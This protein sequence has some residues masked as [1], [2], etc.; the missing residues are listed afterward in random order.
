VGSLLRQ[1]RRRRPEKRMRLTIC[2]DDGEN[3]T[4][5]AIA[6]EVECN[7]PRRRAVRLGSCT[8]MWGFASHVVQSSKSRGVPKRFQS[9]F[10]VQGTHAAKKIPASKGGHAS[11]AQTCS[12]PARGKNGESPHIDKS[13]RRGDE[14]RHFKRRHGARQ[15]PG[16]ALTRTQLDVAVEKNFSAI[17][18]AG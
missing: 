17:P 1:T 3:P 9:S 5:I 18:S 6:R 4:G 7:F 13:A 16:T 11:A 8:L 10:R 12:Q 14:R 15:I 2:G